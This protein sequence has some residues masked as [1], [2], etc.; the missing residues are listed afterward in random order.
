MVSRRHSPLHRGAQTLVAFGLVVLGLAKVDSRVVQGQGA[1]AKQAQRQYREMVDRNVE[2]LRLR[3][4]A[5]DGSFSASAGI[6]P[7]ALVVSGLLSVGVKADDPM[8]AKALAYLE[9]FVQE[10]GGI[11]TAESLH[12]NYDTCIAMV[13]LSKAGKT[14][15]YGPIVKKAEAFVRGIQWDEGEG[16][17]KSDMFFGGAGY[18]S[19]SRP[20][21]S[22]TSFLVDA[23]RTL[24]N[25][26]DDESIQKALTFVSRC[27]NL[28]SP[29]NT[30]PHAAK[31]NDGG[32]YYTVAAGGESKAE[33]MENGGLRSYGSMTYAGLKSM[34]YAGLTKDDPRVKAATEFLRKNYDVDVNPGLGQQG[35]FYYYHTMAKTL[36]A[37]GEEKFK[38]AAGTEHDWKSELRVKLAELQKQDGSWVNETPRWMEGDPN[39]VAGY[40]LLALA[41]C[42]P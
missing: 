30:S 12:R 38:D 41:Y 19:H 7:T 6:G 4:Q 33:P 17:D 36:D 20:D 3:G 28:E 2:F 11:Y 32:F 25:E 35:L 42:Q 14:D 9:R 31:V 18:G 26:A 1:D 40:A 8:V 27:Q 13:A 21:L 5:E 10:D 29:A 16:K 22:N 15:K 23:L 39:L 34:I 37:I 24:G